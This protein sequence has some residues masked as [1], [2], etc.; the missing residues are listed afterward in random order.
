MAFLSVLA[1]CG[2]PDAALTRYT[3]SQIHMGSQAR[4]V[5]YAPDEVSAREAARAA[6]ARM[7]ELDAVMSDYRQDSELMRLSAQPPGD[8]T[9]VSDDLFRVLSRSQEL[10]RSTEGAFDV[11]L[12][13]LT[14]LWRATREEGRIPPESELL[15]ARS[16]VGWER[17]ELDGAGRRVRLAVPGMRL[18]LGA[19]GKG[20]AADE[21]V[22]AM[23]GLGFERCLVDLGGDISAGGP[24]PGK[25]GWRATVSTGYGAGPSPVV[26]VA[27]A[28]VATSGDTEQY[29]EVEGARFSHILDP[30]TGL[31]LTSR[32]AATVIAP[33][34]ATA[35]AIASAAC[36]LGPEGAARL[37][38]RRAGVGVRLVIDGEVYRIGPEAGRIRM[39]E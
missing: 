15:A 34:A 2:T 12:G 21:A 23:R 19:I 10:S 16:R 14:R 28:G 24:P 29:V 8:W 17:V 38:G 1:G 36:V 3:Y 7:A 33:D 39:I 31:G 37:L 6:F 18:D 13:P 30:R 32:A 4:V 35:D 25:P 9:P 27:G 11:T 22:A 5:L 20:F 26:T